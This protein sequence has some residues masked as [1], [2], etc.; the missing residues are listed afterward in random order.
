MGPE[1][2]R[3]E[4]ERMLAGSLRAPNDADRHRGFSAKA[5]ARARQEKT[6]Q[7]K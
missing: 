7:K 3:H 6:C 4:D 1:W 2:I 5:T